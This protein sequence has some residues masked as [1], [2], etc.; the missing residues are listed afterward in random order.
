MPAKLNKN[1]QKWVEALESGE[2][3]QGRGALSRDG[4][5]CCLGVACELAIREGVKVKKEAATKENYAKY[6]G[7]E[8]FLPEKVRKFF[9]LKTDRGTLPDGETLAQKN[10][11]TYGEKHSFKDIAAIIRS[12]PKGLFG[13]V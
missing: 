6:D 8:Y 11:G 13:K 9:G 10:D 5:Y 12:K 1:A 4:D 3:K 2:F 7:E